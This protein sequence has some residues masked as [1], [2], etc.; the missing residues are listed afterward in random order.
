MCTSRERLHKVALVGLD[1]FAGFINHAAWISIQMMDTLV[2]GS[3]NIPG[4]ILHCDGFAEWIAY[5]ILV[6]Y[7]TLLFCLHRTR[8]QSSAVIWLLPPVVII[9]GLLLGLAKI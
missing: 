3:T 9:A 5:S 4:M 2:I 1:S 7:F 8:S 6:A